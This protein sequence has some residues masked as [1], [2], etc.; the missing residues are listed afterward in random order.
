MPLPFFQYRLIF[1]SKKWPIQI[2]FSDTNVLLNSQA[3]FLW[4]KASSPFTYNNELFLN[5]PSFFQKSIRRDIFYLY[6]V[7]IEPVLVLLKV[8]LIH[9]KWTLVFAISFKVFF[10]NCLLFE[11]LNFPQPSNAIGLSELAT[12]NINYIIY[13]L[14][15]IFE[16]ILYIKYK[17]IDSFLCL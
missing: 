12:L 4:D 7:P 5:E 16:T 13:I 8:Q 17:L 2:L 1:L 3:W 15:I 9:T 10:K 11:F 6:Q 14:Y